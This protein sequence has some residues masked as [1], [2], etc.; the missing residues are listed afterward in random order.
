MNLLAAAIVFSALSAGPVRQTTV[1][2]RPH[3]TALFPKLEIR[4]TVDKQGDAEWDTLSVFRGKEELLQISPCDAGPLGKVCI[5]YSRAK[6]ARTTDGVRMGETYA[7]AKNKVASCGAGFNEDSQ[8]V[9]CQAK[10]AKNVTVVFT[11]KG[12]QE[13]MTKPSELATYR[14]TELRWVP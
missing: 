2:D 9:L 4:D 1:I 6:D 13:G 12:A 7:N 14:V 5:V 8:K 3:L 10:S 11:K